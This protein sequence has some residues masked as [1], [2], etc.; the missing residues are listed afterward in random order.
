M[1]PDRKSRNQKF[2]LLP[3][4]YFKVKKI[5]L[6]KKFD[7]YLNQ[8]L[9]GIQSF[10]SCKTSKKLNFSHLIMQSKLI[11]WKLRRDNIF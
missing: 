10:L 1:H 6:Q 3:K 2:S 9:M 11:T 7:L 4:D 8:N 5:E